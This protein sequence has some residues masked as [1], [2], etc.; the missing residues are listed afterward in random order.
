MNEML[1]RI[2]RSKNE[3]EH[4]W[5]QVIYHLWT[6]SVNVNMKEDGNISFY[7]TKCLKIQKKYGN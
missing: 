4:N 6:G 3:C 1:E 5:R 7:C 2:K